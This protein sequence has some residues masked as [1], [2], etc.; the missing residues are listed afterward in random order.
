MC[1]LYFFLCL[2]LRIICL[3]TLN[4]KLR[5]L[6]NSDKVK[7]FHKCKKSKSSIRVLYFIMHNV[8]SLS[9]E[10]ISGF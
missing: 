4:L 7:S 2:Y 1:N 8:T 6:V 9:Y 10:K 3:I 5:A